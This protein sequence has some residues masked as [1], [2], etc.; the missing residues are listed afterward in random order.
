[1]SLTEAQQ[2]LLKQLEAREPKVDDYPID[3]RTGHAIGWAA[4]HDT[5]Q[6]EMLATLKALGVEK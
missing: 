4:A 2:I 5:W 1:M 3:P 6:K